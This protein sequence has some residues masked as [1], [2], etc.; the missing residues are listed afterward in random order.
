L[1]IFW[2]F[3]RENV[4]RSGAARESI[5]LDTPEHVESE[6]IR[7][8]KYHFK[9]GTWLLKNNIHVLEVPQIQF[10]GRAVSTR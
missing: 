2:I 10:S 3:F 1:N 5:F 4:E 9:N 8:W 6:N 7:L